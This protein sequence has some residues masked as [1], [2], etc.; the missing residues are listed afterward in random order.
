MG[1]KGRRGESVKG[2]GR[3]EKEKSVQRGGG[4]IGQ[5]RLK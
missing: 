3:V 1:D 2:Q 5:L 4:G